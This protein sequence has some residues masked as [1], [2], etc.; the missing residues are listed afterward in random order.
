MLDRE[1]PSQLKTRKDKEYLWYRIAVTVALKYKRGRTYEEFLDLIQQGYLYA[2]ST[3]ADYTFPTAKIATYIQRF[4]D[5]KIQRYVMDFYN[6][7]KYKYVSLAKN[8]QTEEREIVAM[9]QNF[10]SLTKKLSKGMKVEFESTIEARKNIDQLEA[11]KESLCKRVNS[12]LKEEMKK[13]PEQSRDIFYRHLYENQ[14]F[15]VL[16][17]S[18]HRSRMRMCECYK[19]VLQQI[20]KR[21]KTEGIDKLWYELQ[22]GL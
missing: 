19:N 14:P 20:Q 21:L 7:I 13:L 4:V 22:E 11:D 16:G 5:W 2:L 9:F 17:E 10:G 6:P 15:S 1:L 3:T 12:I 18:Y 8:K